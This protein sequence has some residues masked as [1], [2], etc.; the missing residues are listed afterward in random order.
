MALIIL[1]VES[2]STVALPPLP[3]N[4]DATSFSGCLISQRGHP[5]KT[6]RLAYHFS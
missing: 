2:E 5:E 6:L 1:R 4:E 3:A